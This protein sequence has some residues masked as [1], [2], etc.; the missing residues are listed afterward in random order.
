MKD[1]RAA[2]SVP[3]PITVPMN[4]PFLDPVT[5]EFV[6]QVVVRPAR[7]KDLAA[8]DAVDGDVRKT[9]L[10]AATLTGLTTQTIGEMYSDDFMRLSEVV[11]NFLGPGRA[12]G[13]T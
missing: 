8:V 9:I 2:Q 12:T 13:G 3:Q 7:A 11:G 5:E 4:I 10:L 6:T 1:K